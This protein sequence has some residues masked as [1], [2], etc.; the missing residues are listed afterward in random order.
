MKLITPP[1]ASVPYSAEAP[2][3]RT[4]T[5]SM[6]AKGMV[7]RSTPEPLLELVA[8]LL[9]RRPLSSTRVLFG[10]M[11]RR[12]AK[13]AP[14]LLEPTE[15]PEPTEDWLAEMRLINSSVLVT[16]CS[17][18]FSTRRMVTGTA[19]SASTRRIAEPVTS[20]RCNWV[21]GS[22][23]VA[24]VGATLAAGVAA[25]L[26]TTP[27][28]PSSSFRPVPCNA[29][30]RAWLWL[31]WPLIAGA[32][33]P[34][35]SAWE[36]EIGRPLWREMPSSVWSSGPAGRS[37]DSLA[38]QAGTICRDSSKARL[39]GDL[40]GTDRLMDN[41]PCVRFMQGCAMASGFL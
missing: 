40:R 29:R 22:A 3:R 21:V 41:H 15:R 24:G 20:T 27:W 17:R 31:S 8:L 11:P 2:S 5:R 26:I 4:S 37:N 36:K 38:A 6:A 10:P 18:S 35:T 9:R 12:S 13:A 1:M 39:K 16:P 7:F 14:P 19:V 28:A 25:A 30:A 33:C 32:V 34:A 23:K